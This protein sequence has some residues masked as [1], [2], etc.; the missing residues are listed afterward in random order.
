[1]LLPTG[2]RAAHCLLACEIVSKNRWLV[3]YH[4]RKGFRG[5]S[6]S[7]HSAIGSDSGQGAERALLATEGISLAYF[8][9]RK[10][11]EPSMCYILE[12]DD[13]GIY[14]K[15]LCNA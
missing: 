9:R 15:Q 1:M 4:D 6:W 2:L 8:K 10:R 7:N 11:Q 5:F 12:M 3:E 13:A 14:W